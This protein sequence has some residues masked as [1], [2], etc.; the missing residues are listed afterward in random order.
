M[1]TR[2]GC[3]AQ[4]QGRDA[5]NRETHHVGQRKVN[6]LLLFALDGPRIDKIK[7]C[8]VSVVKGNN[9]KKVLKIEHRH[10]VFFVRVTD[11]WPCGL[12]TEIFSRHTGLL[13]QNMAMALATTFS[14]ACQSKCW[15]YL[16]CHA[17]RTAL[18][19]GS[20]GSPAF[21]TQCPSSYESSS[22]LYFRCSGV[23]DAVG[24]YLHRSTYTL[25]LSSSRSSVLCM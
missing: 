25:R 17:S 5:D 21:V 12:T 15:C 11:V 19:L 2:G 10:S 14:V 1:T 20:G 13:C 22:G 3:H 8:F 23:V 18:G 9:K 4:Q 16:G 7:F 24:Y 6:Y